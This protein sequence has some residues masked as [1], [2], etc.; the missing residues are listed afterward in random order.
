LQVSKVAPQGNNN[1]F[2]GTRLPHGRF[3]GDEIHYMLRL[4]FGQHESSPTEC[5]YQELL[6]VSATVDTR[7]VSQSACF[8]KMKVE[9]RH[10]AVDRSSWNGNPP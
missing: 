9:L 7:V 2:C 4:E 8:S 10:L 1:D 3:V 6:H 5:V